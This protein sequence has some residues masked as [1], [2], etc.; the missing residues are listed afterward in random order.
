MPEYETPITDRCKAWRNALPV[1]SAAEI[2]PAYSDEELTKLGRDIKATGGM[3]LPII[4]LVAQSDYFL[5]D[6]RSRLDALVHVG[7]KFEIKVV[8]GHVVIDAPGYDI[9]VPTEI[10]ADPDFDAVAFVLSINLR[11]RHVTNEVK[12]NII[13]KVIEAQP[14]LADNA[15]AKMAGVSD[16]TVTSV[17][18]ELKTNSEIRITDRLEASGRK[19]R[20]RKPGQPTTMVPKPV[21]AVAVTLTGGKTG[22][23]RMAVLADEPEPRWIAEYRARTEALADEPAEATTDEPAEATSEPPKPVKMPPVPETPKPVEVVA[24][25]AITTV[26]AKTKPK[27]KATSAPSSEILAAAQKVLSILNRQPSG[28]NYDDLR[29][30]ARRLVD[31][32]IGHGKTSKPTA[33]TPAR[34]A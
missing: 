9:P 31:L 14:N 25:P 13:R 24:A 4:L 7:I 32:M 16:K 8:D 29:K 18:K 21:E 22:S 10:P 23:A 11:R 19:A 15:V 1:H 17:R 20:G 26:P 33:G 27:D 2:I 5:L 6:G 34:A 28:A 12:R 3:K 30:E